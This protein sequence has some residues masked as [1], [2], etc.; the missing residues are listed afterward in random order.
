MNT[1]AKMIAAAGAVLLVAVVGCQ[2]APGNGAASAIASSPSP[3]LP[4]RPGTLAIAG[5]VSFAIRRPTGERRVPAV[6]HER[7]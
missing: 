1:H 2:S 5:R 4:R 3:T 6:V 7:G